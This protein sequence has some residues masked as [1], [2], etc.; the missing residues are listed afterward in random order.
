[1]ALGA[2]VPR[3]QLADAVG[4]RANVEW[5]ALEVVAAG[6]DCLAPDLR[7]NRRAASEQ[8]RCHHDR[9]GAGAD[10]ASDV[11]ARHPGQSQVEDDEFRARGLDRAKGLLARTCLDHPEAPA[12]ENATHQAAR[13]D[14]IVDNED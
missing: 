12:L 6:L 4:E 10:G 11:E 14:H 13:L 5:L 7:L 8:H 3:D 2:P 9:V 1:M